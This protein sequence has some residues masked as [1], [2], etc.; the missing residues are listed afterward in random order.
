[1]RSGIVE[2]ILN[3]AKA[4]ERVEIAKA[5]AGGRLAKEKVHGVPK[6]DDANN[7]GGRKSKDCTLILTE[8]DSA[9]A[10]A[11]AGLSVVGR[12]KYGVF[13]LKGKVLNV[14]DASYKQVTGNME[15]QNIMKI[16]GLTVGK[17]YVSPKQLRYGSIM[18][19][20]DQDHD[21]SHIK[22]LLINLVNH[23]WP[24]LVQTNGF[25]KEFV[26]PIVKVSKPQGKDG[27]KEISFFTIPEYENW[28]RK[29]N[30]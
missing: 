9:K 26:T 13:P 19:M 15:I 12:D 18:I 27:V 22:G 2:T 24:S 5:L 28:K 1:M 16:I 7:A 14:R 17:E 20:T 30:N 4:K 10:L 21:G 11:V 23:W 3:W 8:G 6:L 25:L 29:T